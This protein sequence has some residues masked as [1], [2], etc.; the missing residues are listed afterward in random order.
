MKQS[1][2]RI[3]PSN[4]EQGKIGAQYAS[5]VLKAKKV[6]LFYDT[7]DPYSKGLAQ[8]FKNQFI[9]DGN[10]IVY[11]AEFTIGQSDTLYDYTHAA[12]TVD[13]D[14]IYFASKS[15]DVNI[16]RNSLKKVPTTQ[17]P[18]ASTLPIMGGDAFYQLG[19]Y[20][21]ETFKELSN[22]YF[23]AYAYPDEWNA[24][25]KP[26]PY[27]FF[28]DYANAFDPGHKHPGIYS[29]SRAHSEAIL[30]Y[31]AMQV[32]LDASR[33]VLLAS[34]KTSMRGIELRSVLLQTSPDQPFAG[35]SGRIAFKP[36]GD[37]EDKVIIVLQVDKG[38][39]QL[40]K[41]PWQ[42]GTF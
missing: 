10:R 24:L 34:R 21:S 30:S 28:Q 13:P 8:G 1:C 32:L 18:K 20:N 35:M 22:F 42:W 16:L 25:R 7:G 36:N 38:H 11:Q 15:L 39:I 33:K 27:P 37:P 2:F 14:L 3:V 29:Y 4:R 17:F 12:L 26:P 31:D 19:G 5:A 41:P 6:A 23:T 40:A 9:N